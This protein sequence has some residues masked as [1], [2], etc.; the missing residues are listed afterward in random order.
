MMDELSDADA[1]LTR[2]RQAGGTVSDTAF[3]DAGRTTR[4]VSGTNG[5]NLIRALASTA[6]VA[7]RK[8]ER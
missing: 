1:T 8:A 5:E 6:V 4:F 2:L 3:S 7:W